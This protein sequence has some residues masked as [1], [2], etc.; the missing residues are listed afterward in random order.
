MLG[1]IEKNITCLSVLYIKN[2]G[3]EIKAQ[4]LPPQLKKLVPKL[5][6]AFP[7]KKAKGGRAGYVIG[8]AVK[9]ARLIAKKLK[10][11]K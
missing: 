8:G 4:P 11:K 6:K 7:H 10:L 3:D 9:A 1:I 2:L 5:K